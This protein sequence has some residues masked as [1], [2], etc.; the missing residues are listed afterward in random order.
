MLRRLAPSSPEE[1]RM[2]TRH[3]C[4]GRQPV[5]EIQGSEPTDFSLLLLMKKQNK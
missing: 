3:G 5:A 4:E 2:T 1:R